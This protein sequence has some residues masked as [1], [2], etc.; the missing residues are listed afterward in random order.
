MRDARPQMT[1]AHH[2]PMAP[3][4]EPPRAPQ[5]LVGA[6]LQRG[7][8]DWSRCERELAARDLPLQLLARSAFVV[9]RNDLETKLLVVRDAEGSCWG[10]VAVHVR[11]IKGMPGHCT[12]HA[13]RFGASISPA[14]LEPAAH[15]L[16]NALRRNARALRMDVDVFSRDEATRLAASRALAGAGFRG[17]DSNSYVQTLSVDLLPDDE[18]IFASFSRS[19]RRNVRQID[20]HPL[21]RRLISDPIYIPRMEEITRQTLE[22]TGGLYTPQDW[23]GRIAFSNAHPEMSRI[24]GV[25]RADREGTDAL[26]S[27]AWGAM[28]G[29][30]GQYRDGASTRVE[31]N[32][33]LSYVLIWDM[34]SWAKAQGAVWFDLGGV[35]DGR[36]GESDDPLA[37]IS[38]FKRHFTSRM[39]RVGDGFEL[40][41]TTLRARAARALVR[42]RAL[43][44]SRREH[45]APDER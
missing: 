22:R 38:D 34:I 12:L 36:Q 42:A 9:R 41:A 35:T 20:K 37:G 15:A 8:D 13:E 33:A 40:Q 27:F 11:P 45:A 7:D 3:L 31:W 24:V 14:A 23:A 17:A 4:G 30:H 19:A 32:V 29:D 43:M 5:A 44:R 16:A 21:E 6:L 26:V 1:A 25:F 39:E 28:H 2:T 18:Q 10:A